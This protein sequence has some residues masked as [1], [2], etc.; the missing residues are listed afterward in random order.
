MMPPLPPILMAD[1][2]QNL[3]QIQHW[4]CCSLYCSSNISSDRQVTNVSVIKWS[5]V[6]VYLMT[7]L[8]VW[9]NSK[10]VSLSPQLKMVYCKCLV[11]FVYVII[12]DR[13]DE[14]WR[15]WGVVPVHRGRL[16]TLPLGTQSW[17]HRI[18]I[19]TGNGIEPQS[20]YNIDYYINCHIILRDTSVESE[21]NVRSYS[22]HLSSRLHE[23]LISVL[24]RH[25]EPW[26][27]DDLN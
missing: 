24:L 25:F 6:L 13:S 18:R 1:D 19:I 27:V 5:C 12:I 16:Y 3:N 15:S 17:E 14:V 26:T 22:V 7:C 23:N 4:S 2:T 21:M 10:P 9:M 20:V 8:T 11:T